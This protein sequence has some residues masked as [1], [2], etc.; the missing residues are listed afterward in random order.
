[1][2][3]DPQVAKQT[4]TYSFKVLDSQIVKEEEEEELKRHLT[5]K[6]DHSVKSHNYKQSF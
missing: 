3:I 4:L 1:M 2:R 5:L 6:N